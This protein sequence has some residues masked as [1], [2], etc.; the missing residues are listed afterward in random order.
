MIRGNMAIQAISPKDLLIYLCLRRYRNSSTGESSVPI[1]KIVKLTG[2]SPVTVLN[3]LDRL[4]ASGHIDYVKRGRA[5]YYTFPSSIDAKSYAF[6]DENLTHSEKIDKAVQNA[7]VLQDAI[8]QGDNS[9]GKLYDYVVQL[10]EKVVHL[11]EQVK[12]LAAELDKTIKCTSLITGQEY[13][14]LKLP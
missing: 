9:E 5:N 1:A 12:T 10:E 2:A 8:K 11:S 7:V 13:T 3:S 4:K 14:P 6:L